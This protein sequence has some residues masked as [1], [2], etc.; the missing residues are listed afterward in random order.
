MQY[1]TK[2]VKDIVMKQSYR[3][4]MFSVVIWTQLMKVL[5]QH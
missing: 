2:N 5:Q 1:V 3:S 4:R